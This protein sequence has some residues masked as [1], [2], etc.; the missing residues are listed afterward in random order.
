M[1]LNKKDKEYIQHLVFRDYCL[2]CNTRNKALEEGNYERHDYL[3]REEIYLRDLLINKF[4]MSENY[5]HSLQKKMYLH[6]TY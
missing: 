5:L 6:D 1:Y 2:T 3:I 4:G